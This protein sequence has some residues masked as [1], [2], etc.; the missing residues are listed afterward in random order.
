MDIQ[1]GLPPAFKHHNPTHNV[2]PSENNPE[3]PELNTV[4]SDFHP[5]EAPIDSAYDLFICST[6]AANRSATDQSPKSVKAYNKRVRR[7]WNRMSRDAPE[8]QAAWMKL[9]NAR[10]DD[11]PLVTKGE[12]LLWSQDLVA[13]LMRDDCKPKPKNTD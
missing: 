9:F 10:P 8:K 11:V 5:N 7:H 1:Q 6:T 12:G 4:S 2:I 13:T 3:E